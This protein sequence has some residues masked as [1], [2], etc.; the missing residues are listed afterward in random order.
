MNPASLRLHR[1]SF[2]SSSVASLVSIAVCSLSSLGS[3]VTHLQA[4][5]DW[6]KYTPGASMFDKL[7]VIRAVKLAIDLA[8][9]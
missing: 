8:S 7:Y 6:K 9:F 1:R 3:S 5:Y 4:G 2:V